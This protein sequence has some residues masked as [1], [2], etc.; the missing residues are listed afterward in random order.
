M[1]RNSITCYM[2]SNY[3]SYIYC[4][5]VTILATISAIIHVAA[6][7]QRLTCCRSISHRYCTVA[8]LCIW[9]ALIIVSTTYLC[10]DGTHGWKIYG[11]VLPCVRARYVTILSKDQEHEPTLTFMRTDLVPVLEKATI[12]ILNAIRYLSFIFWH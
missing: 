9:I 11:P 1:L 10:A 7:F 12:S 3:N 8:S 5:R 4:G 2:K 6:I